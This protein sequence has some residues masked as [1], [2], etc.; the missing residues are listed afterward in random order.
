MNITSLD[1]S[2]GINEFAMAE[3]DHLPGEI[4]Q[5]YRVKDA[6]I[7]LECV[8]H[9]SVQLPIPDN[10]SLINR[11]IIAK[12]VGI[13][14]NPDILTKDKRIDT[15]KLNVIARV[16]YNAYTK[17]KAHFELNRPCGCCDK[18]MD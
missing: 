9:Q 15:N 5:T 12:V 18:L 8:Y 3:V 1:F 16:G 7:S 10:S 2:R 4:V 6:P 13:H 14:L 17:V 11:M